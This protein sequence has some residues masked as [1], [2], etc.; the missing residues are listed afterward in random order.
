MIVLEFPGMKPAAK[1]RPRVTRNGTFM[2]PAYRE[3]Q[4]A[5]VWRAIGQHRGEYFGSL[6]IGV[7][8]RTATGN[9][10]PDVDNA[11]GAVLDALQD[12]GTIGNDS[13]V[14][15]LFVEVVKVKR[16]DVG[17]TVTITPL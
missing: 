3:W 14:R 11:A 8:I 9:M 6:A 4:R 15:R 5:F 10:R 17:I 16:Q 7:T 13:Q 12:A 2:P 1:A